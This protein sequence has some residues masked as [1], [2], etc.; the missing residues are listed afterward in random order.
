[1]Q[2]AL[3]NLGASVA[4]YASV[5]AALEAQCAK[6]TAEDEILLFGS[7][8]C[9]GEALEWLTRHTKEDMANGIAR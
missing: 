6:A 5:Q 8:Y 4:S 2:A 3:E 1:L 7:F 9:V